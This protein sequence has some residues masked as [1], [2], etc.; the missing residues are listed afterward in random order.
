M[1]VSNLIALAALT[2]TPALGFPFLG[3]SDSDQLKAY[4]EEAQRVQRREAEPQPELVERQTGLG[5]LIG[6]VTALLG[7]VRGLLGSVANAVDLNNKRPEPGFTFQN[8]GPN[9]SRGPCPGLNL[10]AN[11]GYLP[12]NGLVNFGQVLDATSRGFNMGADLAA[13]LAVFSILANGDIATESFYLGAGPGNV[14]G[15]NRHSTAECDIS[16]IREDFYNA[17]GD[18][19]HM[20]SRR[21]KQLVGYAAQDPSK[22]FNYEVMAR[23][24]AENGRFSQANNPFLY[25]FPFPSIVALG[26][27]PFYPNFFS[28]GTF[29]AGGVANYESVSA[30]VGA[31]LNERT[32]DFEYVPERWPENW[33]RRA[34]PYGAVQAVA[35]VLTRIYPAN[36][37]PMGVPQLGTP[38]LNANTVLCDVYQGI[39]SIT[40]L[41]LAQPGQDL[42]AATGW[43]LSKLAPFIAPSVLGCPLDVLSPNPLFPNASRAGGPSTTPPG[44]FRNTGNNVYNRVYF[45]Q[46]PPRQPNCQ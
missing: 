39:N 10:L 17:C 41:I 37:V 27:Y 15:L 35:D 22:Q 40:P 13:V 31:R 2:T 24:Y 3:T 45:S 20:S 1:K 23:Q 26:A 6:S 25:F 4:L 7:T 28:N 19:H 36:P 29:G 44:V 11:Y 43:A 8:P 42:A 34:V 14:G 9:D 38:N 12:R 32:G 46:A 30:I 5:G 21:F 18:N 16:P 33:Y